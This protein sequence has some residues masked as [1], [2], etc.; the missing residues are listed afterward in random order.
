M[1]TIKVSGPIVSNSTASFYNWLGWDCCSPGMIEAALEGA[2]G[3]DVVIEI[4]SQGGVCVYGYEIYT[5]LRKYSGN[6]T[7]HVIY[8]ASAATLIA[9]AAE[10]ALISD[11]GI[12][13]IHNTQAYAEGDYRDM[14]ESGDSLRQFNEGLLNVY[15]KKTGMSREEIQRLMDDNT[16]MAPQRAIEYGFIDGYIFGDEKGQAQNL[17][18]T[19]VAAEIP[20]VPENIAKEIMAMYKNKTAAPGQQEAI[21]ESKMK[22]AAAEEPQ[23]KEGERIMTLEEFAN[24]SSEARAELEKMKREMHERGIAHE[25]ERMKALDEL[26]GVVSKADIREAKYGEHP[27]DAP[28]L[29]YQTAMKNRKAAE[30]YMEDAI[31]DA[32][33]SGSADVGIGDIDAGEGESNEADEMAAF[34]NK[35]RGGNWNG[36]AE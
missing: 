20:I 13:M 8:A 34:V 30:D 11:A 21:Q 6:V 2:A 23:E 4:N 15:E 12:Y 10:K 18:Q 17:A 25:R 27:L 29:A 1:K 28:V 33:D 24:Q 7:A 14:D 19:V 3:D 16:Y 26:D 32:E 35:K 9:C 5:A 22:E 31:K 36:S